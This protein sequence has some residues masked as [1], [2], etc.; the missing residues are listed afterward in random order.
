[1][2]PIIYAGIAADRNDR[3]MS[4]AVELGTL[5]CQSYGWAPVTVGQKQPLLVGGW[6]QQ[7]QYAR[8]ALE[9]LGEELGR[10]L[11]NDQPTLLFAG[12]CAASIATLPQFATRDADAAL[13]WFDAHGDCNVPVHDISG[14]EAYLGGMVI[15]AAAGAW[16]SGLGSG[17]RWDNVILVGSRDLDPP[18]R[19]R[20]AS[21]QIQLVTA[22]P[23]IGTRLKEAVGNRR[24][25]IHLDCDVLTA[26]L[27]ATEYQVSHGLDWNDLNEAC[28]ALADCEVTGIEI[29]EYESTWPHG[30]PN[31]AS[32]LV[33]AIEPLLNLLSVRSQAER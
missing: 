30:K 8:P 6:R 17:L 16:D 15:S 32:R 31:E 28:R 18:E 29:A 27:L 21:G 22:G 20:I 5:V 26:G 13:V 2:T 14:D 11:E 23:E 25:Y 9:R 33:K 7:L 4:G 19:D 12:R 24:V 10:A 3:A 1:M